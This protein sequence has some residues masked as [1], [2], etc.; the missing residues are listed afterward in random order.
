MSS[1]SDDEFPSRRLESGMDDDDESIFDCPNDDDDN[2]DD[3]FATPHVRTS[4]STIN[5]SE[6]M[7]RSRDGHTVL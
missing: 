5:E 7:A 4:S 1:D 3:V 6:S 2:D